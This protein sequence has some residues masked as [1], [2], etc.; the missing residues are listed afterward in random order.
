MA[1]VR[2]TLQQVERFVSTELP[3]L[4]KTDLCAYRLLRESDV[5]CA[6]YMHLRHLL[7]ADQRW[8]VTARRHVRQTGHF[9]DLVIF[10]D[11]KPRIAIELK[12]GKRCI[13]PKD[14]KSLR[15]ALT[16]LGVNR[17]YWIS[18]SV[19]GR[20]TERFEKAAHEKYSLRQ[21]CVRAELPAGEVQSWIRF[22]D[23][24]RS[25]LEPGDGR[26]RVPQ[27]SSDEI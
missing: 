18:A 11:T 4:L 24:L 10:Q 26:K 17:A 8:T 5:E 3:R 6:A 27:G 9:I 19:L 14:R 20:E 7:D 1:S 12:W 16:R 13:D 2:V 15:E 21:I 22:R 25:K 23:S